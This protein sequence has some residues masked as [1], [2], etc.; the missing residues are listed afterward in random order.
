MGDEKLDELLG[1]S[2]QRTIHFIVGSVSTILNLTIIY[3][4]F[5]KTPKIFAEYSYFLFHITVSI[6]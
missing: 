6:F 1:I 4:I 5:F 3:L 2:I